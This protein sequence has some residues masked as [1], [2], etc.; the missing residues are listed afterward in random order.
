MRPP[1][2]TMFTDDP[3]QV[4]LATPH[5]QT[6]FLS[7]LAAGAGI[8]RLARLGLQLAA[9]G[10]PQPAVRLAGAL[11]Q[12]HLVPLIEA[13]KERGDLVREGHSLFLNPSESVA[14][15]STPAVSPAS[16]RRA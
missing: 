3:G 7:R 10:A 9:A 13:V 15:F 14:Q 4:K 8:W 12:Q 5:A 6:Q 11:Q 16:S 2:V 1:F